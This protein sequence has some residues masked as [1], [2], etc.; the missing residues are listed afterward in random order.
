VQIN[1]QIIII[2]ILSSLLL[3]SIAIAFYFY[4][5]NIQTQKE[6]DELKTVYIAKEDI[7]KHTLLNETHLA[8]TQIATQYLLNTPLQLKEIVGK[9]NNESIFKHE[10]FIKQK[11]DTKIEVEQKK[12]LPFE[13]SM[14]NLKFEMFRNPNYALMQGDR[15]NVISVYPQGET[16]AKGRYL[17]FNV[18][19]VAKDI[20]VLGFVRDGRH[21]AQTVTKHEVQKIINKKPTKVQEEIKADELLL[22]IPKNTLL[23]LIENYNKGTQLWMVKTAA[24]N[25]ELMSIEKEIQKED[26]NESSKQTQASASLEIKKSFP[27]KQYEPKQMVLQQKGV[28]QYND[29]E[30]NDLEK[31]AT[32]NITLD[33]KKRCALIQDQFLVGISNSFNVRNRP[34]TEAVIQTVLR[35]NTFIP[36]IEKQNDWYKLCDD[37]FVHESVVKEV[38]YDFVQQKLGHHENK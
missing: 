18:Q 28:I 12:V 20:K 19:Y 25:D 30:K 32:A 10:I 38:H 15:I 37:N 34:T 29:D 6:K 16:D 13:N 36:F 35:K 8:Q 22:D 9:Y 5:K 17:D 2:S 24:T 23:N 7:A 14:Y 33:A 1:K 21:E 27:Y 26:D 31:T 4:K 3:S 11:L